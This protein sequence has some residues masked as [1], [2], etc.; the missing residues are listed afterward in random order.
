[1]PYYTVA[2]SM[3]VSGAY[4][5]HGALVYATSTNGAQA[6]PLR[7]GKI[8]EIIV[9]ATANPNSTDTDVQFDLSRISTST[10]G[11]TSF[12][13]VVTDTADQSIPS[14][15]AYITASGATVTANS[16]LFNAGVNQRNTVRWVAAQESQYLV[17]PAT[18]GNGFALRALSPNYTGT[19][20]TNFS[21]ME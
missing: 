10:S 20:G 18:S 19:V 21:F 2:G 16:S 8:Y 1:M 7:R 13:P 9:G 5:Q 12:A 17:W 11:G 6:S 4:N 14:A 15:L 3:T